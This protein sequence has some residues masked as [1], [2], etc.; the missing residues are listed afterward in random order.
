M[1]TAALYLIRHGITDFSHNRMYTDSEGPPLNDEGINQSI[2]LARWFKNCKI[3]ILY[4]S[5]AKRCIATAEY[6][7]IEHSNLSYIIAD[8]IRERNFGIWQGLSYAEIESKDPCN[9]RL[10]LED[11]VNFAP[12][13]GESIL[14]L[15][16]RVNNWLQDM[17]EK[18]TN[19]TIAVVSHAGPIRVAVV[20][21]LSMPLSNYRQLIVSPGSVTKVEYSAEGPNLIYSGVVPFTCSP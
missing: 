13:E 11:K 20:K 15:Y 8:E 2:S 17:I 10:W 19:R 7:T 3:D 12:P 6:I 18:N 14:G 5:N 4:S 21:A 9:Y 16:N 1:I